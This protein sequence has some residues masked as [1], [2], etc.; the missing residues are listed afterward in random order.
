[1][2]ILRKYCITATLVHV[3][4]DKLLMRNIIA[5]VSIK[6]LM[7]H[8]SGFVATHAAATTAAA[9]MAE[10]LVALTADKQTAR[11]IISCQRAN[12]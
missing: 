5:N 3:A 10:L 9:L 11:A 8:G 7:S 12:N 1:M 4:N 2:E 6:Q